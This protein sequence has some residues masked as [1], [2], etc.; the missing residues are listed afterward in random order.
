MVLPG[1]PFVAISA[2]AVLAVWVVISL[3]ISAAAGALV[4]MILTR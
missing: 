2:I 3:V 4:M 1:V